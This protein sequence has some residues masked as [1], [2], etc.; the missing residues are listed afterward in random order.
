MEH[1]KEALDV[2]GFFDLLG[3]VT[4]IAGFFD[5]LGEVTRRHDTGVVSARIHVRDGMPWAVS[6]QF[7][8]AA[9]KAA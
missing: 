5:L 8:K 3:E 1:E 4:R 6:V 9:E 2:A 7:D